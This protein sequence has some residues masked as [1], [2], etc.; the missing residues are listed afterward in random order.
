MVKLPDLAD[1]S[2]LGEMPVVEIADAESGKEASKSEEEGELPPK[3]EGKPCD[4][5]S[6]SC[7]I[8][9]ARHGIQGICVCLV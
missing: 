9:T 8:A 3:A 5:C 4:H 2:E 1:A 7:M 6:S